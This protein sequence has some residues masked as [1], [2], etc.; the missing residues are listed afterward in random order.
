MYT[1]FSEFTPLVSRAS[2]KDFVNFQWVGSVMP[3]EDKD[4][5]LFSVKFKGRYARCTGLCHPLT[6]LVNIS[7]FLF[8]P[9]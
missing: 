7:G 1:A 6:A 9:I 3:P 2:T 5:A 8:R 4:A